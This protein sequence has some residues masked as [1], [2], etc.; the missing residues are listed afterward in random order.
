MYTTINRNRFSTM[1]GRAAAVT[2][3]TAAGVLGLHA[4][5]SAGTAPTLATVNLKTSLIAPLDLSSSSSS[6][7]S[8]SSSVGATETANAELFNLGG[9]EQP[10]PRRRYS[11]PNYN[12]SRTNPDGSPKYSFFAGGGFGLPTGGT[13]NYLTTGWGLQF[14]GGRNFNKRFGVALQFDYDHFGLQTGTLNNLLDIYQNIGVEDGFDDGGIIQQV[15]GSTHIWSFTIDPRYTFRDTDKYGA[16]VVGG[17]GFYH[18]ATNITTPGIGEYC[19]FYG[20]F[21]YQA[22]QTIDQYTSNAPGVNGGIGMT[23]KFSRFASARFYAE[24]RY[25]YMFNQARS[26]EDCTEPTAT[27]CNYFNV[28]PQNSAKTSYIPVKFGI[29]F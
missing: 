29:R 19:T 28:F 18:K 5:Q 24:A 11:R 4:Q 13:H 3:F 9:A 10:P 22:N 16:Y 7:A 20:C 6:D 17:V 8:Y 25:V 1:I 21:D 14:G 23:Y 12:D 26:Y 15:G 27:S 2:F